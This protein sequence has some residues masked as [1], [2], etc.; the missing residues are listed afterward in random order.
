MMRGL[1]WASGD[2]LHHPG[3]REGRETLDVEVF[4]GQ[5]VTLGRAQ[6]GVNDASVR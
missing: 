5:M 1:C 3:C 2:Y 4:G 6:E